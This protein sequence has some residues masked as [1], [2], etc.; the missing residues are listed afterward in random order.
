MLKRK[1][2]RVFLIITGI[3]ALQIGGTIIIGRNLDKTDMGLYRL[4]L[5]I[6]ELASLV[7]LLGIDQSFVRFFSSPKTSFTEYDW[8]R[9]LKKFFFISFTITMVINIIACRIYQINTLGFLFTTITAVMVT[10]IFIFSSLLRAMQKYE[11]A[12]FFNRMNFILFF[13]FLLAIFI[14]K[15]ISLINLIIL[16]ALATIL[17]NLSIIYYSLK[18][19]PCGKNPIPLSIIKNGAYYFLSGVSIIL[20][21]QAGPF[22]IAKA[23]SLKDLAIYTVTLSIMRIFEFI[24]DSCFHV[25]APYLNARKINST[26][27]IFS[28][29]IFMALITGFFYTLFGKI[30]LN[31]LFSGTYNGGFKLIPIFI[32]IGITRILYTFPASI[33]GGRSSESALKK[34]AI[35]MAIVSV[36]NIIL[37]LILIPKWGLEGAAFANLIS[38]LLLFI[39]TLFITKRYFLNENDYEL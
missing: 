5:N 2:S 26:K 4:L 24:Q 1:I 17:A 22:I 8:K 32:L 28:F 10:L 6:A 7:S 33:I 16:Y 35:G 15:N 27:K 20:M 3:A 39:M 14:T 19:I 30:I 9:F 13:I 23:L 18:K 38:W 34:Q 36:L 25:L 37:G 29:L 31:F 21:P 12:I 11:L